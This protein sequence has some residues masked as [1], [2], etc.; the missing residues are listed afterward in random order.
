VCATRYFPPPLFIP[1]QPLP[2]ILHTIPYHRWAARG[3]FSAAA[4]E[5][6]SRV[7][8]S[9]QSATAPALCAGAPT[10]TSRFALC[11]LTG[12]A[13][14]QLQP[15]VVVASWPNQQYGP[16]MVKRWVSGLP[17]L[18]LQPTCLA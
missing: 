9:S 13:T 11:F 4:L 1:P 16:I 12:L 6:G 14:A 3:D 17:A 7:L 5:E 18:T 8:I 10:R 2:P 15:V